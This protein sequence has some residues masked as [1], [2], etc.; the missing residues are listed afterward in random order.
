MLCMCVCMAVPSFNILTCWPIFTKLDI[1]VDIEFGMELNCK[2]TSLYVKYVCKSKV[3]NMA[4]M[5]NFETISEKCHVDK[6]CKFAK[7]K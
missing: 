2:Q 1:N 6:F 4:T 5:R 3:T 7:I